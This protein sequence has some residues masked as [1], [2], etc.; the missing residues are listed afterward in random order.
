MLEDNYFFDPCG[1]EKCYWLLDDKAKRRREQEERVIRKI[2]NSADHRELNKMIEYYG[3]L[4]AVEMI[5]INKGI[6]NG[7]CN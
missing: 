6:K 5:K 4:K 2:N 1:E 3:I 7:K